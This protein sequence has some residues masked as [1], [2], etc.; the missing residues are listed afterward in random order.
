M[1]NIGKIKN[2]KNT[3]QGRKVQKI[4]DKKKGKINK[5]QKIRNRRKG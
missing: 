2:I 5:V 1:K 4:K 3:I